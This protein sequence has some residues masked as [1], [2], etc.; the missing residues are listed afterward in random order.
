[1]QDVE[2]SQI[3]GDLASTVQVE[4]EAEEDELE[5]E[6]DRCLPSRWSVS[7]VGV[8]SDVGGVGED[9][10]VQVGDAARV[11]CRTEDAW[12][13]GQVTAVHALGRVSVVFEAGD[14]IRR[15]TLSL[16][17]A[18]LFVKPGLV[19]TD[20]GRP[21]QFQQFQLG[22]GVS[23]T[24]MTTGFVGELQTGGTIFW[25]CESLRGGNQQKAFEVADEQR[26][27][28][29]AAEDTRRR[30]QL[31]QEA[32]GQRWLRQAAE[33][34]LQQETAAE[35]HRLQQQVADEQRRLAAAAEE[36]RRRVQLAQ[37]AAE[38][39]RLQEQRR[40][41]PEAGDV[42]AQ[43]APADD[44]NRLQQELAAEQRRLQQAVERRRLRRETAAEQPRAQQ[45]NVQGRQNPPQRTQD[46][47]K[48]D[49]CLDD[50]VPP[51]EAVMCPAMT[52]FLC[53]VCL[54][55]SLR[56]FKTVDYAV[57][58]KGKGRILCPFK[59]S[60]APFGDAA[61]AAHV[62]QEVFNEYLEVRIKV[63]E[64]DIQVQMDKENNDKLEDLKKKLADVAGSAEQREI[65]TY[66][67]RIL[68]DIFTLNCPRCKLAFPDFEGCSARTCV[69]CS[70]GFCS[71]CLKDCGADAHEHLRGGCAQESGPMYC[72]QADWL[73][74]QRIRMVRMFG[75]YIATVPQAL[76]RKICFSVAPDARDLGI[77]IRTAKDDAD[78]VI[79]ALWDTSEASW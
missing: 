72:E 65:D 59:D 19:V 29:V 28:A 56:A 48:C 6:R 20:P 63:V 2:A 74:F 30:V 21:M 8:A 11:F 64:K 62:P 57:Q 13:D 41:Q 78:G 1:M 14:G 4:A 43:H 25:G 58:K 5:D 7:S 71:Y 18:Q 39:R 77:E 24:M 55:D 47:K 22:Q 61:L 33:Q 42:A 16:T 45:Q 32:A 52:H 69:V 38:Q 70:C 34:R 79:Y 68:E 49:I 76:Q 67:L 51:S 35:Q 53:K 75:D 23:V 9:V 15:K 36:E 31:Q 17:S 46:M 60:E 10:T 50:N 40:P 44:L 66:R 27:L 3:T 37:Q 12:F 73:A 54:Q 26:R